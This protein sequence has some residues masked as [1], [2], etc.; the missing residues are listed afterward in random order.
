MKFFRL[1]WTGL[2]RKKVRTIFTLLSI[3]IAFVLFG[4]LQ[5]IDT[6]FKQLVDQ[7]R[8]NVL[9]STNPAGLPLPLADLPQIEAIHGVTGVTYRGL[10]I[11]DYQSLRNIVIVLPIDSDNFFQLNPMFS[12]SPA[13]REAFLH[14]RT[15]ALVTPA[16]AERLHW[17]AGDQVPLHALNAVKRDGSSDWTFNIVGTF[18]IPGNP[19]REES[20]LLMNF[21]YFDTARATDE[22]TVQ[23]Y[24]VNIADASQAASISNAIDNLFANSSHRTLTET[25]KAN[26]QGQLAQIGGLDFFVEAIVGAAFATLLLLTGSTLMQAFRERTHEFAVMK[27]L[28]FTDSGV[29]ALVISEAVLLNVGAALVGLLLAH[30]LL[31]AVGSLAQGQIPGLHLPWIVFAVGIGVA[32]LLALVSVLPPAWRAQRLSIIDALAVR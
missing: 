6:A 1:V 10:F 13:A 9:V 14:T 8:L 21:P 32:L 19:A 31:P 16:L 30:I 27:T 7:G 4:T 29:A 28:G 2:W 17:K 26:A 20:L 12:I 25:E 15:G 5:G 24:Q 22:G 23:L 11:G 18:D 3:I